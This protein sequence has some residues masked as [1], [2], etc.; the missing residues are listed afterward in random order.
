MVL[1]F[2]RSFRG[3]VQLESVTFMW[4]IRCERASGRKRNR[5]SGGWCVELHAEFSGCHSVEIEGRI[6][7]HAFFMLMLTQ[8]RG[9]PFCREVV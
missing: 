8:W 6:L 1:L 2:V 7:F 4:R 9:C 3:L 5:S